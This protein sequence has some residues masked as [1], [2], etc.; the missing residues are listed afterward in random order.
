VR[1]II[2]D[3]DEIHEGT[4][5]EAKDYLMER[6]LAGLALILVPDEVNASAMCKVL[7]R[8]SEFPILLGEVIPSLAPVTI[9]LH[10]KYGT[11]CD[12]IIQRGKTRIDSSTPEEALVH[13]NLLF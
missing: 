9:T 5:Q 12:Y 2:I 1:Y 7:R 10:Q 6:R 11:G 8:D 13:A 3:V 4:H